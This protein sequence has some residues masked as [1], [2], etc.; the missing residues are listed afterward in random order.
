MI[1]TVYLS[2][3]EWMPEQNHVSLKKIDV[4]AWKGCKLAI[5]NL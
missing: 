5:N 2:Q 1:A 4:E 3:E